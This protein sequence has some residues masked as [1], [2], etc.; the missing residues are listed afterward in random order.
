MRRAKTVE[1]LDDAALLIQALPPTS[2]PTR[3][4]STAVCARN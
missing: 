2:N 4:P 1:A 3:R